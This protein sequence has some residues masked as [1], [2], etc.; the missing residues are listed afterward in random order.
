MIPSDPDDPPRE[1]CLVSRFTL[2]AARDA[3]AIM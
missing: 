2:A 1:D 3:D